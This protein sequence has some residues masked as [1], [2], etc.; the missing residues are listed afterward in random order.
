MTKTRFTFSTLAVEAIN[1]VGWVNISHEI[2]MTF[3]LQRRVSIFVEP[4]VSGVGMS[5]FNSP[6]MTYA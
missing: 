6:L 1:Y 5:E 4:E 2:K 3:E